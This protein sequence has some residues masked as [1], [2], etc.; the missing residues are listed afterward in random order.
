MDRLLYLTISV[1][2]VIFGCGGKGADP[3]PVPG[4]DAQ[5]AATAPAQLKVPAEND[6]N[7]AEGFCDKHWPGAG[8]TAITFGA[9]P[10]TRPF[11]D[12][13][14]AAPASAAWRWINYWATWCAPCLEEMPLLGRWRDALA[15]EGVPFALELWSVDEDEAKLRKRVSEGMPGPITWVTGPTALADFLTK[16]AMN[17]DSMLPIQM[18]VDPNDKLRCVR[19]GAVSPD[20]YPTIRKLIG[21]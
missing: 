8:P 11:G 4:G 18:L 20:H 9:G 7:A 12:K 14:S 16:I 13:K 19:V 21:L 6:P 5:V 17:P 2:F 15:K 3:K 10:A 1:A